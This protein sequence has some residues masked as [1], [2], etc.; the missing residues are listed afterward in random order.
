MGCWADTLRKAFLGDKL[1]HGRGVMVS[2]VL[3]LFR[4]SVMIATGSSE[5]GDGF[6]THLSA[7]I[8]VKVMVPVDM[9]A[10]VRQFLITCPVI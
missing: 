8:S 1:I 2:K 6:L 3:R 7:A 9:G 10:V 4:V 5:S